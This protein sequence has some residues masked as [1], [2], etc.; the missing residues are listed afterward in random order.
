M[1][2][3]LAL[4]TRPYTGRFAP[5]PTGALHLGSLT[6]AAASFL[7]ARQA[8]GRWLLRIEDLDTL[9][10][11]PGAA[12][13]I[14]RTL[15]QLGF[16]WDGPVIYQSQR[17]ASYREA[18]DRLAGQQLLYGCSCS[19]REL[20]ATDDPGG[21]PGTCRAGPLKSGPAATRFRADLRPVGPFVDRVQGPTVAAALAG[22]DP[23][24][25]RRD[26]LHAYQLAVVVD[27]GEQ[28]VT[29]VVRG[30]DLLA[31]TD[32]QRSL[33]R[34]LSWP[35]PRY[36]HLPL[37]CEPGGGKLAK[38]TRAVAPDTR[39]AAGQIWQVLA[40]LRQQ[41]PT[42]LAT[43]ALPALW[44]WAIAHWRLSAVC[45]VATLPAD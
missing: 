13:A 26:G 24:V 1:A 4:A 22:G 38:S 7:D 15:E 45:G 39:A 16:W 23:I 9:R 44:Q 8:G 35:E 42:D 18:L 11:L 25:R 17:L 40:L 41:P 10:S 2:D 33:Q 21:Y 27:D 14:L 12:D 31:S 32:W 43:A 29:D 28:G 5:S 19:R 6:T 3:P 30:A 37:V 34:A 36:A 20:G